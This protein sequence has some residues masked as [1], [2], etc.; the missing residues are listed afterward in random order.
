MHY[1]MIELFHL[2]NIR[3]Y[4]VIR[5]CDLKKINWKHVNELQCFF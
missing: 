1:M 2:W 4:H 3:I 5:N